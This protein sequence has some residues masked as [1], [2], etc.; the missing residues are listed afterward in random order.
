MDYD[1]VSEIPNK[2]LQGAKMLRGE[3][4]IAIVRYY[5]ICE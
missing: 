2:I 1:V 5:S 4:S 3:T